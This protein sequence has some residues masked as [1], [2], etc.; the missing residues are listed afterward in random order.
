MNIGFVG[1]GVMGSR[2]A[3]NLAKAGHKLTVFDAD[4]ATTAEVAN[5]IDGRAA[6]SP[7]EVAAASEIVVTMLPNGHVVRDVVLGDNGLAAGFRPSALLI[8][9][10][11]AEPWI[12]REIADALAEQKVEM[13][14]APVSGAEE[15]ARTATLVFMCG[16][17]DEALG[18]ARP[19]LEAMGQ[20]I[21]HVGPLGAGHTM[22]AINNVTTALSF[23]CTAEALLVGKSYGLNARAMLDV[24]NV[25]TGYSFASQNRF[26]NDVITR[27][28][29]DRFRLDLMLKDMGIAEQL[30]SAH[31][32]PVPM[33]AQGRARW[34]RAVE[35]LGPSAVTTEIVRYVEQEMGVELKD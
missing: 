3:R 35:T 33:M 21:F 12:A 16:G 29:E 25:S 24:M 18:R 32:L 8:D 11:S 15:G 5:D 4:A 30:A 22:K 19:V 2:M 23:L 1:V 26:L 7:S 9:C 10:S 6:K 13:V 27:K 31:D 20:H 34:Q 17:S 28:F 14:D